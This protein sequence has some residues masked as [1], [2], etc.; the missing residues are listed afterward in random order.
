MRVCVC[1]SPQALNKLIEKE[2]NPY[3]DEWERTKQM[4]SHEVRI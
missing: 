4:P 3:V 2:I 1:S